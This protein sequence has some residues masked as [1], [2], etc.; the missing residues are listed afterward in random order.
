VAV[1]TAANSCSI[2]YTPDKNSKL[3]R[4]D[5]TQLELALDGPATSVGE[6]REKQLEK[7]KTLEDPPSEAASALIATVLKF[8][9]VKLIEND[10]QVGSHTHHTH[11]HHTHTP[12]THSI[13]TRIHTDTY[14]SIH[15]SRL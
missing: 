8:D 2:K 4:H 14:T 13:H 5:Y 12:Y 9:T 15:S 10:E 1:N 11:T 7:M 6:A 3:D